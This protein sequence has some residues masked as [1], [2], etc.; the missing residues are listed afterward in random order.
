[1]LLFGLLALVVA[2]SIAGAL[3]F[4]MANNTK[5]R[6]FANGGRIDITEDTEAVF[7]RGQ[8][9]DGVRC[10]AVRTGGQRITLPR[11]SRWP[12]AVGGGRGIPSYRAV[13]TLPGG[14]GSLTVTCSGM[15]SDR[16]YVGEAPSVGPL[17]VIMFAFAVPTLAILAVA[18]VM[19]R[20]MY[21]PSMRPPPGTR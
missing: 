1:M 7:V 21:G 9:P 12:N 3:A 13:A 19:R 17:L 6:S 10:T 14:G 11:F 2:L 4:F 16:L 20:R 18:I 8:D 15:S 5:P